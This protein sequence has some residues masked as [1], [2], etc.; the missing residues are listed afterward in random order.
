MSKPFKHCLIWALIIGRVLFASTAPTKRVSCMVSAYDD[1]VSNCSSVTISAFTVPDGEVISWTFADN[2][3]VAMSGDITFE[4]TSTAGPL[5]TFD[6]VG[7]IFNGAGFTLD[8]NGAEYWDG[9][10]TNGGVDKP[11]PFIKIKGSGTYSDL[12]VLNSPAQAVSVGGEGLV[13]NSITIDNSDGDTDSLGH[14]TDGFDVSASSI[15][16]K[17]SIVKNQDDCIAINSGSSITFE[18][19]Q[20][21]GGHGTSVGSVSSGKTVSNVTFSGNTVSDSMYGIRI[22]VKAEADDGASVSGITYSGNTLTGIDKFGV[23]ISQSYPDDFGTPGTGS[24]ISDINFIGSETSIEVSGQRLAVDCG[25][26][27]GDWDF[28]QLAI[29]GGEAGDVESE[30]ATISG[31]SH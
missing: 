4:K 15:T 20:C 7:V 18:N 23:L 13:L 16:I 9:E 29:T 8:G 12:T 14:N 19:N 1:D 25:N 5:A 27:S 31:G 11:H 22:K 26:C 28:S 21:S 10:G 17:N 2:A 6:G 30:D 24:I 3:E